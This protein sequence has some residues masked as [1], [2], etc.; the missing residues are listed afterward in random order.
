MKYKKFKNGIELSRLGMGTMRMP[1][2]NGNDAEIDFE[3][4]QEIIDICMKSGINYYDTAY[5][6][7]EGNSEGFLGKALA[8]YPRESF[9]VADKCNLQ[10]NP[11]YREQFDQ[12]LARLQMDYIDFYLLHAIQ[13]SFA[14]E[15][16][17]NGCI[18]YFDELK[19]QG[20][21]KY[22]GFSFHGSPKVL[23]KLLTVY[24][25][26]FVQIQLNY[27]DWFFSDAKELYE[28]LSDADIPVMVM[29][30]MHGGMLANLEE[31]AGRILKA[32]NEKAS[33][34]SWAM[35]WVMSLDKV[36]VVLS[37]MSNTQQTK[38]NI[39]TFDQALPLTADDEKRIKKAAETQRAAVAVA[40][41]SCRYCC[42]DCPARLDIP[43]LIK[44][45]NEAKVGGDWR[46]EKL[47]MLPKEKRPSACISCGAC[48]RHCPQGFTIQALM[49]EMKEKLEK[50]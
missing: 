11:D 38:D 28:I 42:P 24:P 34:A 31:D 8:K 25:W 35:R 41:T 15:M 21:I 18:S 29:E 32:D 22:L 23:S 30:P 47:M 4:A 48:T 44:A 19:K 20:K 36:Q 49:K 6:Y 17:E 7:H 14:D 43:Y 10:A 26:D 9:Y 13:D 46:L 12:Q 33:L 45:Y 37:G 16:L 50:L 1:V 2:V 39:H 5:V 40:C 27:Y 3:K